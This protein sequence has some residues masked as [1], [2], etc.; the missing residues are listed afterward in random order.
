M[1]ESAVEQIR[2]AAQMESN[3][4][5]ELLPSLDG[6]D[7]DVA[8]AAL[9]T[10]ESA[11]AAAEWLLDDRHRALPPEGPIAIS[12]TLEGKALVLRV[13]GA[14]DHGVYL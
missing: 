13:L 8:K 11:A 4:R 3:R 5:E 7:P 10:F 14:I 12:R 1:H 9:E 2:Q 6:L